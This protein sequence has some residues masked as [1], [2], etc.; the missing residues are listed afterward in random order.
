VGRCGCG[1]IRRFQFDVV[2]SPPGWASRHCSVRELL[3]P[4][5]VT[6]RIRSQGVGLTIVFAVQETRQPVLVRPKIRAPRPFPNE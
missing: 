2:P 3:R 6:R 1:R 4:N 5:R